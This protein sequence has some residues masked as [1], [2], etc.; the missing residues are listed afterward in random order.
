MQRV[1][2]M[3][4]GET[5]QELEQRIHTVEWKAIVEGTNIAIE[6]LKSQ[7]NISDFDVKNENI[8]TP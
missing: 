1:V 5:L 7:R 8:G 2:D 3:V 6:Q 4:E